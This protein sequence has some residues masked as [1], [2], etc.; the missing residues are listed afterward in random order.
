[1]ISDELN[2]QMS[3]KYFPGVGIDKALLQFSG[4][5]SLDKLLKHYKQ[6]EMEPNENAAA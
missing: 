4:P 3:S 1:M 2:N 5:R 6:R